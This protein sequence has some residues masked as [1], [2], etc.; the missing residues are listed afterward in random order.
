MWT[1]REGA[2]GQAFM[3]ADATARPLPPS[4][5]LRAPLACLQSA[6]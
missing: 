3:L 1:Y 5:R 2:A 6:T 4:E